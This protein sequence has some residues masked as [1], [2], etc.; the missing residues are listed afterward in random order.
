MT[1][2]R[3]RYGLVLAAVLLQC[4]F[5]GQ[6]RAASPSR[7]EC[8]DVLR[9]AQAQ[10]RTARFSMHSHGPDPLARGADKGK[11]STVAVE[12]ILGTGAVPR[13]KIHSED[14]GMKL[15]A[16]EP[17]GPEHTVWARTKLDGSFDGNAGRVIEY[18]GA[19]AKPYGMILPEAP[20]QT[21]LP[22]M[23]RHL[24]RTLGFYG[25]KGLCTFLEEIPEELPPWRVLP[26]QDPDALS[27]WHPD[28]RTIS[29][30]D[31]GKYSFVVT[32]DL[33]RGANVVRQEWWRNYGKPDAA[34]CELTEDVVLEQINGVWLPTAQQSKRPT[35]LQA[36]ARQTFVVDLVT[37]FE[38]SA[39]NEPIPPEQFRVEFPPGCPIEDQILHVS[40]R[41]GVSDSEAVQ[42]VKEA[43]NTFE[44][45]RG[46]AVPAGSGETVSPLRSVEPARAS[47][48]GQTEAVHG[49]WMRRVTAGVS[50]TVLLL[51]VG[52]AVWRLRR[53]RGL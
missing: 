18:L 4:L 41:A 2:W 47:D 38:W 1:T 39:V 8:L 9:A 43:I 33:S 21:D 48:I 45:A 25:G 31:F 37:T 23:S 32:L 42:M 13:F 46:E 44:K 53:R 29:S 12:G 35:M 24:G 30:P 28:T 6:A 10:F 17:G 15:L 34:I 52:I 36:A 49:L 5:V 22:L 40:Y 14:E 27:I 7:D 20:P 11:V 26:S 3:R 50:A 19:D 51:A 16:E